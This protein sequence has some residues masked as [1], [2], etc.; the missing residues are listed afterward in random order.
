VASRLGCGSE[1]VAEHL[2]FVDKQHFAA[3][4]EIPEFRLCVEP[5]TP[6][7]AAVLG[8]EAA[9]EEVDT[10]HRLGGAPTRLRDD[11]EAR[12]LLQSG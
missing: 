7:A 6:E 3:M 2:E 9:G 1:R 11:F 8:F 4:K 10:H 5:A 12:A